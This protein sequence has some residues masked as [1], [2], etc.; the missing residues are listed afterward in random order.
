[1]RIAKLKYIIQVKTYYLI[2]KP[3]IVKNVIHFFL[4][5]QT[6]HTV[7]NMTYVLLAKSLSS[8]GNKAIINQ[9]G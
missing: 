7:Y 1:M 2:F 9:T 8:G 4:P 3:S 5:I 6:R